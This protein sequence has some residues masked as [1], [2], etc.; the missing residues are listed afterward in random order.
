MY[1]ACDGVLNIFSQKWLCG[2]SITD[3]LSPFTS[4]WLN[5]ALVRPP[6]ESCVQFWTLYFKKDANKWE[7][8]QRRA[9]RMIRGL[10]PKSYEKRLKELGMFSP[11]KRRQRNDMVILFKYLKSCHIED[12][13]DLFSVIPE[14]RTC[15][16]GLML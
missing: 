6:L 13:H 4:L 2:R 11:E 16:N 10:E 7:Q 14:C 15:N 5:S 12:R 3:R 8:V 9:T 1:L